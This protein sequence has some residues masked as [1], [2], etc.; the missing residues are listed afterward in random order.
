MPIEKYSKIV[1]R[2]TEK[3]RFKYVTTENQVEVN[4]TNWVTYRW[5]YVREGNEEDNEWWSIVVL[6]ITNKSPMSRW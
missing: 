4:R 5:A 2:I 1:I 3:K 6:F